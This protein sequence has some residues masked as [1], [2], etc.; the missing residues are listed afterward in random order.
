[1]DATENRNTSKKLYFTIVKFISSGFGG[2]II[3]TLFLV[4]VWMTSKF[5]LPATGI[6]KIIKSLNIPID[7]YWTGVSSNWVATA[8]GA[9]FAQF[10]HWNTPRRLCDWL[11]S[12]LP[13]PN[14]TLQHLDDFRNYYLAESKNI[15]SFLVFDESLSEMWKANSRNEGQSSEIITNYLMPPRGHLKRGL[16]GGEHRHEDVADTEHAGVTSPDGSSPTYHENIWRF[17]DLE[18]LSDHTDSMPALEITGEPGSG[19]SIIMWHFFGVCGQKLNKLKAGWIPLLVF[20]HEITPIMCEQNDLKSMLVLYYKEKSTVNAAYAKLSECLKNRYEEFQLLVIIDGLDELQDR[21]K[22]L[23]TMNSLRSLID[24]DRNQSNSNPNRYVISCR[25]NDS[26]RLFKGGLLH[27]GRMDSA[28]IISHLRIKQKDWKKRAKKAKKSSDTL[29][30]A[31]AETYLQYSIAARSARLSLENSKRN[32][33]LLN[34]MGNPFL[35]SRISQYYSINSVTLTGF[36]SNVF[37]TL[38]EREL[39]RAGILKRSVSYGQEG[40]AEM[41]KAKKHLNYL[42]STMAPL[43]FAIAYR[44]VGSKS[45]TGQM[46]TAQGQIETYL[47]ILRLK[48]GIGESLYGE[49]GLPVLYSSRNS[50]GIHE[51]MTGWPASK[52]AQM[53]KEVDILRDSPQDEFERGICAWLLRDS[54]VELHLANQVKIIDLGTANARLD[55]ANHRLLSDYL[56]AFALSSGSHGAVAFIEDGLENDWAREPLQIYAATCVDP[57]PLFHAFQR[58]FSKYDALLANQVPDVK[59]YTMFTK[60]LTTFAGVVTYL[61]RPLLENDDTIRSELYRDILSRGQKAIKHAENAIASPYL[62]TVFKYICK[63]ISAIF[64]SQFIIGAHQDTGAVHLQHPRIAAALDGH[65]KLLLHRAMAKGASS[66]SQIETYKLLFPMKEAHPRLD[67]SRVSLCWLVFHAAPFFPDRFDECIK[68]TRIC[69]PSRAYFMR[70]SALS[71]KLVSIIL[72]SSIVLGAFVLSGGIA[73]A[74]IGSSFAIGA[75]VSLILQ[76]K[77]AE[78][79]H[80]MNMREA[81]LSLL[82]VTINGGKWVLRPLLHLL[83]F[84]A[85]DTRLAGVR[86]HE[87]IPLLRLSMTYFIFFILMFAAPALALAYSKN[88]ERIVVNDYNRILSTIQDTE[89]S[90]AQRSLLIKKF[91]IHDVSSADLYVQQVKQDLKTVADLQSQVSKL[92]N[93]RIHDGKSGASVASAAVAL[94]D[95]KSAVGDA[96]TTGLSKFHELRDLHAERERARKVISE[97]DQKESELD[98]LLKGRPLY[99]KNLSFS[100]IT[101]NSDIML[102]DMNT[103]KQFISESTEF[104]NERIQEMDKWSQELI[105]ERLNFFAKMYE[106][107]ATI[108]SNLLDLKR[109]RQLFAMALS[110]TGG[111]GPNLPSS[112]VSERL[113]ELD[114]RAENAVSNFTTYLHWRNQN[115]IEWAQQKLDVSLTTK[116]RKQAGLFFFSRTVVVLFFLL[117]ASAFLLT[118]VKWWRTRT[119]RAGFRKLNEC[120]NFDQTALFLRRSRFPLDVNTAAVA[121]LDTFGRDHRDNFA[122]IEELD[123]LS[124][125][126]EAKCGKNADT[127]ARHIRIIINGIN[128]MI[129]R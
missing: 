22:Y 112:E 9:L 7:D 118:G 44:G 63:S 68:S 57:T 71:A 92:E 128:A 12:K 108:K 93:V 116:V 98:A 17:L 51:A 58:R 1:M 42:K 48:I 121:R 21:S 28:S 37:D 40:V 29:V 111:Y 52:K 59:D 53:D 119:S 90:L 124:S 38:I 79:S 2:K 66:I 13:M 107:D 60:M 55:K 126:W 26:A 61:P 3:W 96:Y 94:N 47:Q 127:I 82:W 11:I 114:V 100:Q 19:K 86:Q 103:C 101:A 77:I 32:A 33:F 56:A 87:T 10:K 129:G 106:M 16:F 15:S 8:I 85:Q 65:C 113:K 18:F 41:E 64:S 62:G 74:F 46:S 30:R 70:F 109:F 31:A 95:L 54:L 125:V 110:G 36:L 27:I 120:T 91:P 49:F 88:K 104:K 80:W 78:A 25:E 45:L 122:V 24:V 4:V 83:E 89:T 5:L 97:A 76:F 39:R 117:L 99:S 72:C 20:G 35:L 73:D 34:Y 105:L 43:S 123:E 6:A 81:Y 75:I 14:K 102:R 115:P 84:Q 23:E 50:Q 69:Y 67:V